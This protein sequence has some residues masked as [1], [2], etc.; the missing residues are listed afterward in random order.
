MNLPSTSKHGEFAFE[1]GS[2]I[3]MKIRGAG[4]FFMGE[5]AMKSKKS[6]HKRKPKDKMNRKQSLCRNR[7]QNHN[8]APERKESCHLFSRKVYISHGGNFSG[9]KNEH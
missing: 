1:V 9:G 3:K 7:K 4:C 6:Q 5:P 8:I 2:R